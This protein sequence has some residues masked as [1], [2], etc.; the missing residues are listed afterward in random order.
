MSTKV[1]G[2]ETHNEHTN[3]D[4]SDFCY[5]DGDC[6][7]CFR[8]HKCVVSAC[9]CVNCR[10]YSKFNL[11]TAIRKLEETIRN[12]AIHGSEDRESA[13]KRVNTARENYMKELDV[14]INDLK[15]E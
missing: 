6:K 11:E 3:Y 1:N 13:I 10:E 8:N 4:P 2:D 12:G 5:T 9:G 15:Y 7:K 14:Y